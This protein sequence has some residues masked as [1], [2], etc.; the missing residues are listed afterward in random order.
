MVAGPNGAG[1]T[2][3]AREL[4]G[5]DPLVIYE[6]VNADEI[7]QGLAPVHPESM[8]LAASK[9]MIKR[10]K[11]LLNLHK[12]F[13]FETT[14]AGTNYV[15]HLNEAKK[16]GYEIN[17]TFLWLLS[18]EEAIRR[19]EERKK[20]GGHFIPKETIIRRYHSG[21]RNL[22]T[23][24]LPLADTANILDNSSEQSS[25]RLVAK[26]NKNHPLEIVNQLLWERLEKSAHGR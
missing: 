18:P 17:L 26:K 12:N 8:A 13:A 23:F 3:M 4:M 6:F 25:M 9:L 24:Y 22:L 2:T 21:L 16:T 20:Q 7:A 14:A 15:R 10:I 11:D 5:F 1:K 19:V